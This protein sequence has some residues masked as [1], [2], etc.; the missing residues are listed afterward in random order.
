MAAELPL[1][2]NI[3]ALNGVSFNKGCYIGQARAAS[4]H[5]FMCG[6]KWQMGMPTRLWGG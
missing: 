3:E 5:V 6:N 1:E 4:I 2:L